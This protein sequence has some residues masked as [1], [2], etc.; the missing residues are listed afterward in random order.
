MKTKIISGVCAFIMFCTL[1]LFATA[2]GEPNNNT[3]QN[4]APTIASVKVDVKDNSFEI[5]NEKI[6]TTFAENKKINLSKDNFNVTITYSDGSQNTNYTEYTLETNIPQEVSATPAGQYYVKIKNGE[7][8][9]KVI[10]VNVAK[11][12]LD[13]FAE[14]QNANISTHYTGSAISGIDLINAQFNNLIENNNAFIEVADNS[15]TEAVA[16]NEYSIT[17]NAN[18][19]YVFEDNSSSITCS[20]KIEKRVI[21]LNLTSNNIHFNV[22]E[23]EDPEN[24]GEYY[25][26]AIP[27]G[28]NYSF[29]FEDDIN[30]NNSALISS[31]VTPIGETTATTIG[32]H[33]FTVSLNDGNSAS[34]C[35]KTTEYAEVV[36]DA[37]LVTYNIIPCVIPKATL[38]DGSNPHF[39]YDNGY[40][41]EPE[42]KTVGEYSYITKY[43]YDR[44]INN[45]LSARNASSEPY[46]IT[47]KVHDYNENITTK[48]FIF[49]D[50]VDNENIT[51]IHDISY[52][53]Y[54]DRIDFEQDVSD[55]TDQIILNKNYSNE[56]TLG[57]VN[58]KKGSSEF[59][60]DSLDYLYG[61]GMLYDNAFI[62]INYYIDEEDKK[63]DANTPLAQ[64]AEGYNIWLIYI[65]NYWGDKSG[66]YNPAYA[67]Y[68]YV[69]I[70]AK[71][72][73]G[74]ARI[75]VEASWSV[76]NNTT[77]QVV[78]NSYVKYN[79]NN[80]YSIN[81]S[82]RDYLD[83]NT[84][85]IQTSNITYYY[86]ET[87]SGR[88]TETDTINKAGWYY[89]VAQISC[90]ENYALFINSNP[91][92][93][94]TSTKFQIQ[95]LDITL[96][97]VYSGSAVSGNYQGKYFSYHTGSEKEINYI[98][99]IKGLTTND[100]EITQNSLEGQD[101]VA[102]L[103]DEIEYCN[104]GSEFD[105]ETAV[106]KSLVGYYRLTISAQIN[107]INYNVNVAE[108]VVIW[109][110]VPNE[111]DVS[112]VTWNTGDNFEKVANGDYSSV[113]LENIPLGAIPVIHYA[114]KENDILQNGT[115]ID[116]PTNLPYGL[117]YAYVDS[118]APMEDVDGWENVTFNNED[119]IIGS[120]LTY[121]DETEDYT[122]SK[123]KLFTLKEM[124]ISIDDF[125][126][127]KNYTVS[128]YCTGSINI[129]FAD[130]A[131]GGIDFMVQHLDS[132][133]YSNENFTITYTLQVNE[134]PAENVDG[135]PNIP[136]QVGEYVISATITITSVDYV[137]EDETKT[138]TLDLIV[139]II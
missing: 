87:Q 13:G 31:L 113:L 78:E 66:D 77:S 18:S 118:F 4:T 119:H 33:N 125:I 32:S 71:L 65:H 10:E 72:I 81:P 92:S 112:A 64:N 56:L 37:L 137:F 24:M 127:I 103:T 90:N 43:L 30:G 7:T 102:E 40:D 84:S 14:L 117:N 58:A 6:N 46:N 50:D 38:T 135:L 136:K 93:T 76:V 3:S 39:S 134:N 132:T 86:C 83:V 105:Y 68:N 94:I 114:T 34:Y 108:F 111:I 129:N 139:T 101:A 52:N 123:G 79:A 55:I 99:R 69:L 133:T 98:V 29:A 95:K 89:A 51:C 67:N 22:Q 63:M 91:A 82:V 27:V 15:Q 104:S 126:W 85:Q 96:E 36:N 17:F 21:L 121:D 47:L 44:E 2:C 60:S 12:Q 42:Y 131:N 80:N 8:E 115:N 45:G 110:I 130:V 138:A 106:D 74:V 28:P 49:E 122:A 23:L 26:E 107:S 25:L 70:P 88:Y 19:N 120:A 128:D 75:D 109:Q 11:A 100:I 54:I 9:L 16:V 53:F 116:N 41:I 73:V 35:F 59:A 48:C 5:E 1:A 97:V 57:A 62:D 124:Q 61:R 20:W